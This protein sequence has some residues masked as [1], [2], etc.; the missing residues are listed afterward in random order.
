MTPDYL[1]LGHLTRDLL[2]DGGFAPGGTALYSALTACRLGART[3]LVSAEATLPPDWPLGVELALA[4]GPTP[5]FENRY[6]PAGR[7]QILHADA[8]PIRLEDVPPGWRAAPL[9]HLGPVLGE[10]PEALVH[11]FP[12]A[13]LGV[14]PQG[15][16]RSWATP[17]PA[18]VE[19]RPWRPAPALLAAIGALVL[20]IEDVRG[21]EALVRSYARHCPL[22]ALTRGAQGATLFL[23]GEPHTIAAFPTGEHDPTGAGDVF[24]AALLLR[25]RETNDPLAAAHFAACTAALSI[26]GPGHSR[27]PDRA[28]VERAQRAN[29]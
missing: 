29:A 3:A 5:I 19:Y 21:D 10:T 14:T 7:S 28:A 22:V 23:G 26:A 25:L 2:P 24:A 4:A 12:Q 6:G 27:I 8:T 16:M 17:L 15:W 11:A 18:P 1:L 9:V 20:S 13:L